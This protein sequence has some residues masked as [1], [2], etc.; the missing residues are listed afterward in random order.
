VTKRLTF[1]RLGG[2]LCA[3]R[4]TLLALSTRSSIATLYDGDNNLGCP[5]NEGIGW[6]IRGSS[7]MVFAVVGGLLDP[8]ESRA[9]PTTAPPLES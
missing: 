4:A 5:L 7:T 9:D 6:M 3:R 1:T 8:V 2:G